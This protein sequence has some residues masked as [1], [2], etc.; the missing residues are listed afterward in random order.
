VVSNGNF[1]IEELRE[2]DNEY[3]SDDD[4]SVVHPDQY[5]DAA[6]DLGRARTPAP[7]ASD[8]DDHDLADGLEKLDCNNHDDEREEWLQQQRKLRRKKR[9]S[10]GSLHKRTISQ[11]IGSDTDDEDL[12]QLDANE[13]GSTARR[14]RR[15]TGDRGSLLFSDPPQMILEMNEPDSDEEAVP[16]QVAVPDVEPGVEELGLHSLPYY[17]MD[18]DSDS[19]EVDYEEEEEEENDD[20]DDDSDSDSD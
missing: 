16:V 6:S 11:S 10:A 1:T 17:D 19:M 20:D 8:R 14:L 7:A 3:D 13:A 4:I 12:T 2:S 9:L 18:I 5:E 15:K